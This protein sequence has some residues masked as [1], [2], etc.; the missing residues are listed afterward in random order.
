MQPL[1]EI[2]HGRAGYF[3]LAFFAL[4]MGLFFFVFGFLGGADFTEARYGEPETISLTQK[5]MSSVA[6][7]VCGFLLSFFFR[8]FLNN[9]PVFT[10]YKE[11]FE[12]NTNGVSTGLIPWN[13]I[14]ALEELVVRSNSG[15]GTREEATLAIHLHDMHQFT[16]NQPAL[17]R[18]FY[19]LAGKTGR[20][21]SPGAP[22]HNPEAVPLLIPITALGSQYMQAR[23]LLQ[24]LSGL[25]IRAGD[26]IE[27]S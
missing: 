12:S 8:R 16:Q 21:R 4:V 20:Y 15:S 19:S 10:I 7:L 27:V 25:K 22:G 6:M 1:L 18:F 26:G 13:N 9:P 11:G 17:V 23:E 24:Q 5:I 3:V 2:R 14:A